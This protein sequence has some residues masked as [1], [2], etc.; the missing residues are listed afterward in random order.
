M[1]K[2]GLALGGGSARGFAHIGVL[3]VLSENNIVPDVIS[4]CSMGALIG[5][6]FAS[7]IELDEII[8]YARSFSFTQYIDFSLRGNG[9]FMRGRK[10]E[11]LISILTKNIGIRQTKIPFCCV[12]V[13]ICTGELVT[14]TD[15]ALCKAIRASISI[16]GVFVPYQL[17]GRTFIDG[18]ILERL[19]ID[20]ARI[21][22]AD[23]VVAVDVAP[24]GQAH[25]RPPKNV[26]ETIE[27]TMQI[28]DWYISSHKE[29]RADLL[30]L[31][32]TY[33]STPYSTRD[34]NSLIECGR[35]AA[36]DSLDNLKKLIEEYDIKTDDK[37]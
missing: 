15:G 25:P 29:T 7:G 20:S 12:A 37:L 23:I 8:N 5:G 28:T 16:P 13:D 27:W 6:L 2:F 14:F 32:D 35:A 36:K 31:P 24:R 17:R 18:Q 30:I 26:V 1:K 3:Q 4:G 10:I 21:L 11:E 22:G 9:G 33:D 34:L 19:P